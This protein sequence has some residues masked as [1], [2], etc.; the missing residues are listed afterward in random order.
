MRLLTTDETARRLRIAA[1][2]V[3]RLVRHGRL[4]PIRPFGRR[5]VRFSEQ[6]VNRLIAELREKATEGRLS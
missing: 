6:D 5:A 3:R 4:V 2:G 1:G